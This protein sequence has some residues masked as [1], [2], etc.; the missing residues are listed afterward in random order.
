ML[1]NA[2]SSEQ[3]ERVS[4]LQKIIKVNIFL[5]YLHDE[6]IEL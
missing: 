6:C 3:Y 2:K 5:S 4:Q 1:Q